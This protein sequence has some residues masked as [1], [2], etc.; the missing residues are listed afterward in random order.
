LT[1]FG[2]ALAEDVQAFDLEK[3]APC[4]ARVSTL[5]KGMPEK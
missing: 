4:L 5:F 1:R 2:Q 3:I